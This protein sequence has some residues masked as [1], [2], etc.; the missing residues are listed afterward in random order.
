M[1]H[2]DNK[3]KAKFLYNSNRIEEILLPQDH[4]KA[5][6]HSEMSEIRGHA[7]ALDYMLENCHNELTEY[8]VTVMHSLL[9]KDMIASQDR[10]QY[11][12]CMVYI[13]G[14]EA[15]MPIQLKPRMERLI[16]WAKNAQNAAQCWVIHD[17]FEVI[18]PFIDGNGRTGRLILNWVRLRAGL[19]FLIVNIKDRYKYYDK[20]EEYRIGQMMTDIYRE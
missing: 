4:Y 10:G 7:Q 15:L 14:H 8:H 13:G 5:L 20:I 3:T 18:H 16:A 2:L 11:R 17:E 6:D 9:M 12:K 1:E 19:P